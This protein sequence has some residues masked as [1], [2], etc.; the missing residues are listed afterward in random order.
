M[1]Y[2]QGTDDKLWR[3]NL[4]GSAG[5]NLGGYQ[6]KS[7]PMV[8][9]DGVYF[10]GTDDKL[11]KI[12]LDGSGGVYLGGYK[13][14]SK[15]VVTVNSVYFQGTDD[16]LWKIKLDGTGGTNLSGYKTKSSP[17][18]AGSYVYFQG[19]DDKL[20]RVHTDGSAGINLGLFTTKSSPYVTQSH[21]YFQGTDDKLWRT[22]L[23]G[24]NGVNLGGYKTSSTP[25]VTDQHVY[26]QGTD[27]KLWRIDLDGNGGVNLGG[28]KAKS[29]PVVDTTQNFIY[30]QGTDDALWR[31]NLDGSGGLRPGGFA[32]ASTPF[33]VQPS[34][35]PQTG[36]GVA[37]YTVLSLVYAPPGTNGGHSTSSV[38][39]GSGSAL[40]TTTSVSNSFKAGFDLGAAIGKV[41][42]ADFSLSD[43]D[44]DSSSLEIKKTASVD[45][46]FTGPGADGINHDEDIF[47]LWLT[48]QVTV[49]VDPENN[50]DWQLNVSGPTMNIQAVRVGWLKNPNS[51]PPGV[52]EQLTLARLTAADYA[53]ILTL[54]PFAASNP[55]INPDRFI[56][57]TFSFPYAPPFLP[58]DP[59]PT[60]KYVQ[61]NSLTYTMSRQVQVQYGVGITGEKDKV[62]DLTMK[63]AG[64]LQWTNTAT[65]ASSVSSSQSAT[66]AVGGP[67]FGY[68][69][70]TDVL[71]YWDTVYSTYMFAFPS[72]APSVSGVATDNLGEP[73]AYQPVT[74]SFG[75]RIFTTFTDGKG[76]FR[77]Y[78]VPT[79][80]R[81][82]PIVGDEIL[83]GELP[84]VAGQRR[85][86]GRLVNVTAP[87]A[88]LRVC[89][90]H[91]WL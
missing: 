50:L 54:D 41:L 28:Y 33:V 56:P 65:S 1:I 22:T 27:D 85:E 30:F 59:V 76:K 45:L 82:V 17:V 46:T 42:G 34:N 43:T 3:I 32:T 12:N 67:A 35:Q 75:S 9:G 15:P 44:T 79:E 38:D 80:K 6:T 60:L 13:T 29:S 49:T 40:G 84:E 91:G 63:A 71:V 48:P 2:F 78:Q 88:I 8:F 61:T 11:W 39:Y 66:I 36:S 4:D 31:L 5:L 73:L 18:V 51:M 47:Y 77:F 26:F 69:G 37:K 7:T 57:T 21:A 64:Q 58:T 53:E 25:F 16:K 55:V 52:Q 70:P 68:T 24:A 23:D 74:V 14:N 19:T 20:W 83:D 90:F 86:S 72:Q 62:L 10:Q 87:I 81:K 89:G